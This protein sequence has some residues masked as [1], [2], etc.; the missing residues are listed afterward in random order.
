MPKSTFH[1]MKIPWCTMVV[2]N[3]KTHTHT[4]QNN[5][6]MNIYNAIK[7]MESLIS[8]QRKTKLLQYLEL[9]M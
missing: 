3:M 1:S 9:C 5:N 6:Y 4:P 8:L 7:S 2:L